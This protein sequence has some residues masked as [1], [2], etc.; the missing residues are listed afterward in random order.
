MLV[1]VTPGLVSSPGDIVTIEVNPRSAPHL[2]DLSRMIRD[3][4]MGL[5][6]VVSTLNLQPGN[7]IRL[8]VSRSFGPLVE[9]VALALAWGHGVRAGQLVLVCGQQQ[10]IC[11]DSAR[12]A[13]TDPRSGRPVLLSSRVG[14]QPLEGD[15]SP[16]DSAVAVLTR[17]P[18]ARKCS[19]LR[20]GGQPL[21]LGVAAAWLLG[22]T[23][24]T[25]DAVL[26]YTA[27]RLTF[28]T[29][30]ITRIGEYIDLHLKPTGGSA[31]VKSS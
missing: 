2:A 10:Y 3:A 7:P 24:P 18:H 14:G 21:P 28:G 27:G 20:A 11:G 30:D 8:S 9:P 19:T 23:A 6:D 1:N 29:P 22:A 25:M 12:V 16:L 4:A 31:P 5:I 15:A 26:E 13:V 17:L